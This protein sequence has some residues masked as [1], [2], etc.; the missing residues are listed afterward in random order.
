ML[1]NINID[2]VLKN[3]YGDDS[4][5]SMA[6]LSGGYTRKPL[7][8]PV[9]YSS[10]IVGDDTSARLT[11]SQLFSNST[12]DDSFTSMSGGGK[13]RRRGGSDMI[14]YATPYYYIIDNP[15]VEKWV[16]TCGLSVPVQHPQSRAIIV[17]PP[18]PQMASQIKEVQDAL[19]KE[20]I[21]FGTTKANEFINTHKFEAQHYCLNVYGSSSPDN[22]G[23]DYAVPDGFPDSGS[24]KIIR[25]TARSSGVFYLKFSGAN[26]IICGTD[27][28]LSGSTKLKFVAKC[29]KDVYI[30]TG[31]MP[32]PTE[33]S[34][35]PERNVVT[36]TGGDLKSTTLPIY[37]KRL[38]KYRNG[39]LDAAAY[40]F[41]GALG[42][43]G[44]PTKTLLKHYSS[45]F[46]HS[47]F[48]NIFS[49]DDEKVFLL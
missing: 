10:L 43:S 13:R 18:K 6:S 5:Q 25:R 19:S 27:K 8:R 4:T 29:E 3:I 40:D 2:R 22:E 17:I 37:F 39:D 46:L 21:K 44:T 31:E 34:T 49:G 38:I 48:E 9:G 45:N 12:Y 30:L 11:S 41:I 26:D 24:D 20:G 35:R 15:E 47:A 32:T 42:C 28:N 23:M 14:I 1:S 7:K 33:E 36:M 16:N